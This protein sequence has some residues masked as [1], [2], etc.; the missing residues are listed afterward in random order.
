MKNCINVT[1]VY[2]LHLGLFHNIITNLSSSSF[3]RFHAVHGYMGRTAR[4]THVFYYASRN[5]DCVIPAATMP[6]LI[7][8]FH[9]RPTVHSTPALNYKIQSWTSRGHP[10]AEINPRRFRYMGNHQSS[11][12]STCS[13]VR[14]LRERG[15]FG[16][17]D[18]TLVQAAVSW[19][20]ALKR[21]V[22]P[23]A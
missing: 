8:L 6:P 10:V 9:G 23:S 4:M 14:C 20:R 15:L 1:R 16:Q 12:L 21:A 2:Y 19:R 7:I 5:P 22:T 17:E 11:S 3:I 18:W 13:I